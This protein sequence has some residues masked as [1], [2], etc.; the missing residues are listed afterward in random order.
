[1]AL[2]RKEKMEEGGRQQESSKKSAGAREGRKMEGKMGKKIK[3][4]PRNGPLLHVKNP[5]GGERN[6]LE[7]NWE[8]E[9]GT[10]RWEALRE[11]RGNEGEKGRVGGGEKTKKLGDVS[12]N[13]F[14]SEL[15]KKR[16]SLPTTTGEERKKKRVWKRNKTGRKRYFPLNSE[17]VGK[18]KSPQTRKRRAGKR[19]ESKGR[20]GGSRVRIDVATVKRGP[21]MK[22]H[23]ER[24]ACRPSEKINCGEKGRPST[25]KKKD[26]VLPYILPE[27]VRRKGEKL[28]GGAWKKR[29]MEGQAE[30]PVFLGR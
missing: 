3:N 17:G 25:T 4:G 12:K 22:K 8:K 15:E 6:C 27:S 10:L 28:L 2:E 30:W 13:H 11:K 1:M 21:I 19:K 23:G 26:Q 20:G 7:E 18:A 16:S 24:N 5:T 29:T 9:P 14:F